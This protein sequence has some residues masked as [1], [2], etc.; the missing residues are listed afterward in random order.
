M[1]SCSRT[2]QQKL[3]ASNK[4]ART[5]LSS[6]FQ[7]LS[8]R[9]RKKENGSKQFSTVEQ[10]CDRPVVDKF[11]L[12]HTTKAARCNDPD[13]PPRLRDKRFVH[14]LCNFGRRSLGP[15]RSPSAP[16][17]SVQCELR[18]DKERAASFHN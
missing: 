13:K 17:V 15:R 11:N 10:D 7:P 18:N 3:S 16:R 9:L 12:H 4:E 8:F 6:I 1:H 5:P 2:Q 14:R